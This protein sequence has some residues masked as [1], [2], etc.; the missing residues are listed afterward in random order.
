MPALRVPTHRCHITIPWVTDNTYQP[1][2]AS[3]ATFKGILTSQYARPDTHHLV[4]FNAWWPTTSSCISM[5]KCGLG[6]WSPGHACLK[7]PSESVQW[8]TWVQQNCLWIWN[9]SLGF[10]GHVVMPPDCKLW[11]LFPLFPRKFKSQHGC[12]Y[13]ICAVHA[14]TNVQDHI[15]PKGPHQ[16]QTVSEDEDG[17][18]SVDLAEPQ[19]PVTQMIWHPHL[20]GMSSLHA[21]ICYVLIYP[22][23]LPCD[24][25]GNY[26]TPFESD[27][28]FTLCELLY[29]CA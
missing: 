3:S 26:W 7:S 22:I 27:V 14:N 20:M 1:L 5:V 8:P 12:T 19:G 29:C 10:I 23:A 28:Q 4:L 13:H 21:C 18:H 9:Q 16:V 11:C 6:Q 2:S 25:E 24:S 15:H 17:A